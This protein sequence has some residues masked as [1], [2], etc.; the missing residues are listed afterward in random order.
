MYPAPE[1]SKPVRGGA[2]SPVTPAFIAGCALQA[3]WIVFENSESV[4]DKGYPVCDKSVEALSQ[5]EKNLASC[6]IDMNDRLYK[7]FLDPGRMSTVQEIEKEFHRSVILQ[8]Y[9]AG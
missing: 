2:Q 9:W 3:K 8:Q 7:T 5:M 1:S 6:T 4:D